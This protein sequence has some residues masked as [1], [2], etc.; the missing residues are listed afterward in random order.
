[1]VILGI[2]HENNSIVDHYLSSR[3]AKCPKIIESHKG[4]MKNTPYPISLYYLVDWFLYN[5]LVHKPQ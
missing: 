2:V 1:M 3:M 4:A 5:G